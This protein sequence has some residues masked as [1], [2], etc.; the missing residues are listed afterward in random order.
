MV[1]NKFI[2]YCLS[3]VR[4]LRRPAHFLP[5]APRND[6]EEDL[7]AP[8]SLP[9]NDGKGDP[10]TVVPRNDGEEDPLCWKITFFSSPFPPQSSSTPHLPAPSNA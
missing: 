1:I 9:R 10:Y 7:F 8:Y 5:T 4:L 2:A 3:F 6:G